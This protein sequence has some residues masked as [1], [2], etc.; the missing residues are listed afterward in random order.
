[1]L[2]EFGLVSID[3]PQNNRPRNSDSEKLEMKK[4]IHK[5]ARKA[6]CCEDWLKAIGFYEFDV[7]LNKS[8]RKNQDPNVKIMFFLAGRNIERKFLGFCDVSELV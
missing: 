7:K 3:N 6:V 1:M 2:N 8:N 5:K 4:I